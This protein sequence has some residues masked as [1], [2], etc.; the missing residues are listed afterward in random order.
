M[1]TVIELSQKLDILTENICKYFENIQKKNDVMEQRIKSLDDRLNNLHSTINILLDNG[2]NNKNDYT[3]SIK[4][5][6]NLD[7]TLID[8]TSIIDI[9]KEKNIKKTNISYNRRQVI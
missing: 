7:N 9:N 1:V 6:N 5:N 8:N 2:I 3:K 4:E